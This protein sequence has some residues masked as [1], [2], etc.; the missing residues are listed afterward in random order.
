M[1]KTNVGLSIGLMGFSGYVYFAA[2]AYN[3][4]SAY[5]YGP[6][7]FPQLLSILLFIMATIFLV[8]AI[9]PKVS[10]EKEPFD[11]SGMIR[12]TIAIGLCIGFI[13]LMKLLG[14]AIS[15]M[16][17]L[18]L[19]MTL[20]EQKGIIKRILISIGVSLAAWALFRLFLHI[21]VPTGIF[22]FTF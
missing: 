18:F 9:R 20:L 2:M 19:L 5:G 7:F 13:F 10:S 15:T 22:S 11:K 8:Q 16:I 12:L 6:N 21:P 1:N 3:K 14:F 4:S 17:F